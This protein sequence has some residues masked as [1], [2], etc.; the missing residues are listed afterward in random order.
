[1]R[2]TTPGIALV[3]GGGTGIGAATSRRLAADGHHVAIAGLD[4]APIESLVAEIKAAGGHATA[5]VLDVA[6]AAQRAAL[7]AA[8]EAAHGRLDILVNNAAI[9]GPGAMGPALDETLEHFE[10]VIA[11]NLT[12]AFALSQLAARLMKTNGGG[13]IVNVSSVGAA[14][15]QMNA[16]AYCASKAGLDALT[17][18]M[19][20]E[21]APL[22][23][24]VN[25]IAPGDIRPATSGLPETTIPAVPPAHPYVRTT[26]LGRAGT[27][28]EVAE[29]I[30]FLAS[31]AASFMI[32]AVV[33]ADGGLLIY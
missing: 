25:S 22:G 3:T 13:A 19:A 1:M 17:R 18:N 28:E 23:I 9:T 26:P 27:P 6:N 20:L 21:W 15:A 4:A 2:K 12:G 5:H 7:F 10:R 31:P 29:V 16:S 30:A 11:V 32:G 33:V 24:R 14:A 8:I